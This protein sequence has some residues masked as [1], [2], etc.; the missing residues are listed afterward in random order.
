MALIADGKVDLVVNSPVVAVPVLTAP[1]SVQPPPAIR[2]R[3]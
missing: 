2:C 3:C 1:T